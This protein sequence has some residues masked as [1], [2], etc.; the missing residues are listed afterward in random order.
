MGR[1]PSVAK[2]MASHDEAL[3]NAMDSNSKVAQY[4]SY[5]AHT[6]TKMKQAIAEAEMWNRDMF[7]QALMVATGELQCTD[8]YSSSGRR[9]IVWELEECTF[10]EEL[11]FEKQTD[12]HRRQK[13]S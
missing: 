3:L 8:D 13:H 6:S 2:F 4:I 11:I 7:D 10:Q 9:Q 5:A 12:R 1:Q